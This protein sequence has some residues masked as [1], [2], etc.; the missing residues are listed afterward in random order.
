MKIKEL[1]EDINKKPHVFL[2]L[3]GVQTDFAGGVNVELGLSRE[4]AKLKT[5]DE[6]NR[7]AHSSPKI[8]REFFANLKPLSSGLKIVNWLNSNNIPYTILS[9]PLRGP[10]AKASIMGKMEW[11]QKHTPRAVKGAIFK[12]DKH[13]HAK[14]GGRPNILIDDYGK[15]IKAWEQAGGIGIK[16]EDQYEVPDAAERTINRLKEI[17]KKDNKNEQ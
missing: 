13:Q 2:D 14:D 8:V 7:L 16:H 12:H 3:D 15:K 5:E 11:L 6:I 17:F 9:A 1:F 10:Y 4:E